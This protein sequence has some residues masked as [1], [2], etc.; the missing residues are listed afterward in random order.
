MDGKAVKVWTGEFCMTLYGAC[1]VQDILFFCAVRLLSTQGR[2]HLVFSY[3]FVILM[4]LLNRSHTT[5]HTVKYK[6]E[7]IIYKIYEGAN[8]YGY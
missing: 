3:C 6:Q 4:W 2:C 7:N 1:F 5:I 8:S